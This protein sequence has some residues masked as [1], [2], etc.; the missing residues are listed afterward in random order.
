MKKNRKRRNE[1]KNNFSRWKSIQRKEKK[2]PTM[3]EDTISEVEAEDEVE[4]VVMDEVGISTITTLI[5]PKEK[6]QPGGEVEVIQ[7]RGMTDP[8]YNYIIV[9]SLDIMLQNV[10]HQVPELM[11]E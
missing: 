10:E 6:A 11:L 5:M 4:V 2:P 9:K 8:K 3:R 1:S 7:N